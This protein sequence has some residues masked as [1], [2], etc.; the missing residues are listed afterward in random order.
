[1]RHSSRFLPYFLFSL[2]TSLASTSY[3][4]DDYS[5][6]LKT[7]Y[8][9]YASIDIAHITGCK[10]HDLL[11][12]YLDALN[13]SFV[14]DPNFQKSKAGDVM[15]YILSQSK[16]ERYLL[17][18]DQSPQDGWIFSQCEKNVSASLEN[19]NDLKATTASLRAS[20]SSR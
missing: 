15:D 3:A 18:Y 17:G 6:H 20:A 4:Q 2:M 14:A 7:I 13:D 1:M 11:G 5:A 10:R 19:L 16:R 8:Q 12:G 9:Y